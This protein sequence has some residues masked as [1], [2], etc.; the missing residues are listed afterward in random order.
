MEEMDIK[1]GL[2]SKIEGKKLGDLMK[3]VFGN[4]E[5]DQ[6]W[7]VSSYGAMQPIRT[8]LVSKTVLAME[9][10]TVSVPDEEV[11]DTMRKRNEF[12]ERA[13]GFNSKQRLKRLKDKAKKGSL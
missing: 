10:N 2:G 3:D 7:F 11:L 12:L 8:K 1:R 4:V 5:S 9:I 6:G 13:T